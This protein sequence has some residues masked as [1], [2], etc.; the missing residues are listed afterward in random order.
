MSSILMTIRLLQDDNGDFWVARAGNLHF[1]RRS[2]QN[3]YKG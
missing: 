2:L 1:T 3:R